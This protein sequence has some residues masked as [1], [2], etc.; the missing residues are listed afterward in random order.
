MEITIL[1]P[2]YVINIPFAISI[3]F[4]ERKNPTAALAWLAVLFFIPALG[5][6][7]YLIFGQNFHREKLFKLKAEDDKKLKFILYQQKKELVEGKIAFRDQR[8]DKYRDLIRMLIVND[9]A[10][11]TNDNQIQIYTDGPDKFTALLEAI[12]NAKEHV[13]LEY[14]IIRNDD[15]GKKIIAALTEKAKEGVEVR[16]LY[17]AVG[18]AR[19]PK[20]FFKSL[21]EAGGEAAAFFPSRIPR[22]N[23]RINYRNHRK[24]AVIDGTTGFV[25]GFNIGDEYLGKGKLGYWRDTHVKIDGSAVHALQ[26]RF[27]LDWKHATKNREGLEERYFLRQQGTGGAAVQ[28]VSSGPDSLWEQIKKGY[29]KQ[30]TSARETIYLQSPYFVPDESVAEALKIAA[31]SGVDVRVMIPCKPDHPFVY[32]TGYSYIGE[33]LEAGVRA[34]TYDNGFIHSKTL[35]VD[36]LAASVGSANWDIRSFKLNF[37]TNAF[38]YDA[39]KAEELKRIFE[40]DIN[41]CTEITKE[42]YGQRS[43]VIKIKE[44]IFRLFSAIL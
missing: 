32:W 1:F 22:I 19:L 24:I 37:E 11:F 15:L 6:V 25:G 39:G 9:Q 4:I 44:S 21:T 23:L 3:I 42:L 17:D 16:L 26:L 8:L 33:L 13:H 40:N 34:Y 30:I 29:I 28:I 2:L 36:G 14:Y 31:L 18:C 20:N 38:I 35:V 27:F 7:L 41:H 43:R 12:K 10:V 5:F